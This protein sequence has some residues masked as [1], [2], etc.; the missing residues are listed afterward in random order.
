MAK[1]IK[2]ESMEDPLKIF[3]YHIAENIFR[4]FDDLLTASLVSIARTV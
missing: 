4:Q 1:R 3:P 2:L